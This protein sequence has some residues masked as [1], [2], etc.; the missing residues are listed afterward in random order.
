VALGSLI[1]GLSKIELW[2]RPRLASITIS[3]NELSAKLK[4][5]SF[6]ICRGSEQSVYRGFA[7]NSDR[8]HGKC[9]ISDEFRRKIGQILAEKPKCVMADVFRKHLEE[10]SKK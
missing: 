7:D 5:L 2:P 3:V 4:K 10:Q 6:P 8:V 1:K 9:N